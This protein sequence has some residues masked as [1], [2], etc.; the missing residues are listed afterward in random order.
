MARV[1]PQ[2]ASAKWQQRLQASSQQITDGVNGVTV[3][4]GVS[5][6]AQS[7]LWLSQVQASQAKWKANVAAVS[8]QSWQAAMI[9]V[10]IP[11]I[12]QGAT[13]NVAKVTSFFVNFLPFLDQGVAKVKAMPKGGINNSIARATA[14]IQWNAG[15]KAPVG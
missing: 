6:A 4:P 10:G 1:T 3:A 11:R 14:M 13:N 15:Y 12:S 8:L 7:A 9:N 2:Q 5:A